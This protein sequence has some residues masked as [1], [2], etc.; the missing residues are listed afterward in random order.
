MP[1]DSTFLDFD[2]LPTEGALIIPG[3]LPHQQ[4]IALATRLAPRPLV[5]LIEE[6]A[7]IE[8][9]TREYLDQEDT[10]AVT[11]SKEDPDPGAI[12]EALVE[13]IQDGALLIYI[14][15]LIHI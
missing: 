8:P 14:L 15:S 9:A 13:K 1:S 12:G 5:W 11:F 2:R 10:R 6:A 7:V 4:L 3:R